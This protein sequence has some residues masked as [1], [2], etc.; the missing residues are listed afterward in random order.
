MISPCYDPVTKTDCPNRHGGCAVG[1]KKWAEY[2]KERDKRYE[3]EAIKRDAEQAESMI[4]F[5]R[6]A[7][8][9]MRI[10]Y[11]NRYKNRHSR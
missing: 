4:K 9:A 3:E 5:D 2:L 11:K 1:C 7:K 10:I 8:R 6:K